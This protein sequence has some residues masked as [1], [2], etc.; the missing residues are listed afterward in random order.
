MQRDPRESK[1]T[2]ERRIYTRGWSPDKTKLDWVEL[3]LYAPRCVAVQS[4][5]GTNKAT[6]KSQLLTRFQ[7]LFHAVSFTFAHTPQTTVQTCSK[8]HP[9]C[10]PWSLDGSNFKSSKNTKIIYEF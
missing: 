4:E 1:Q 7:S 3:A 5:Y 9:N 2:L 8:S 6:S 10:G